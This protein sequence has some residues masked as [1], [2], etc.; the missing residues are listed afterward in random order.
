M[1][2]I[3]R[4]YILDANIFIE[5]ARR[6]YQFDFAMPFWN[7]LKNQAQQNIICSIDKVYDELKQ[8]NDRLKDWVINDFDDYFCPTATTSIFRN[9]QHLVQAIQTNSQ[10]NQ[11]AKDVFMENTNADTWVL[12]FAMTHNYKIVTHEV[13]DPNV[14]KRVPIPNVCEEFDIPYCDTFDMLKELHFSF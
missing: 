4:K 11:R 14:K 7:F 2:G 13:I 8:G 1:N 9:Y 12:A 5:A 10:Y 3:N 6:Y